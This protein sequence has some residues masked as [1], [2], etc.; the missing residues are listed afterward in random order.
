[1][2]RIPK[3]KNNNSLPLH[4]NISK[5]TILACCLFILVLSGIIFVAPSLSYSQSQTNDNS[6]SSQIAVFYADSNPYGLTYGEWTA[7]W[8]QW[9]YSVPRDVNPSYD[10][11]GEHCAEGQSGPVWF[12]TST[13]QHPVD[14]HCTIPAGKAILITILNSECSYAEFPNLKTEEQLRQCAKEMQDS[15]TH[16]EAS[17]DG[18]PI[19]GLEQYRIQ[20]PLFNFTLPENNIL[21]LPGNI[22]TQSVSDGNYLF[23]KPLSVGNHTIYFKGSLRNVT[24]TATVNNNTTT[25]S[26]ANFIFAGPYGWDYPT[27]YHIT[28]TNSS[29]V[30]TYAGGTIATNNTEVSDS[31]AIDLGDPFFVQQY[32]GDAEKPETTTN[33]SITESF[34]GNGVLNRTLAISAEGNVT[35][36]FRNNETSYLQGIGKYATD[37]G[38]GVAIYNFEAIGKYYPNG[39]FE[40]RGAAVFNDGA[41]GELSPLSNTVAIYKDRVDSNGN[42][43]FLMWHWK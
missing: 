11:T 30:T 20:S 40:S 12:L 4:K 10:D 43:T 35:E 17:I 34:V 7:K 33:M 32:Q 9:A 6:G 22:T 24:D 16:V 15:V 37:N 1:M 36:T 14:R 21:E 2:K 29:S 3:K 28:V 42:G 19:A 8:W 23:L 26:A 31:E 39:T 38:D 18:V 41:T 13:Y 25:S 5:T 27:T